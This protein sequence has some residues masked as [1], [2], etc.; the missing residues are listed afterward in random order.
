MKTGPPIRAALL[1]LADPAASPAWLLLTGPPREARNGQ[2][3]GK[4]PRSVHHRHF[5][6][7]G[8][9][10]TDSGRPF[11][12]FLLSRESEPVAR[13]APLRISASSP[14]AA[15]PTP[16]VDWARVWENRMLLRRGLAPDCAA[17]WPEPCHAEAYRR[18]CEPVSSA[19]FAASYG[20]QRSVFRC[21]QT[22]PRRYRPA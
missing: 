7:E 22:D 8:Q 16:P 6:H 3:C 21:C 20:L 17:L 12:A 15:E 2:T 18:S 5:R 9:T 11:V 1:I 10:G 4:K 14:S 13:L 19:A